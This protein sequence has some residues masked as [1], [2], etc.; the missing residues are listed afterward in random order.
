[1][2]TWVGLGIFLLGAASGA[3][4]TAIAFQGKIQKLR[5]E[6][7]SQIAQESPTA[8]DAEYDRENHTHSRL[9]VRIATL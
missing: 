3:L 7:E 1:M 8:H 5:A 4:L 9:T 2:N 6:I